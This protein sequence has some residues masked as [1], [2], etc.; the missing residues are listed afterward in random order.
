MTKFNFHD[1][2]E[3]LSE[4]GIIMEVT[5]IRQG[6]CSV[7]SENGVNFEYLPT[8]DVTNI[9]KS[10]LRLM[11]ACGQRPLYVNKGENWDISVE[12]K[13]NHK[14]DYILCGATSN[15]IKSACILQRQLAHLGSVVPIMKLASLSES[16][17]SRKQLQS[18]YYRKLIRNTFKSLEENRGLKHIVVVAHPKE[19]DAISFALTGKNFPQSSDVSM[20]MLRSGKI[21]S[22]FEPNNPDYITEGM[23]ETMLFHHINSSNCPKHLTKFK[24]KIKSLIGENYLSHKFRTRVR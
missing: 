16:A 7:E 1:K 12:S 10:A 13:P 6:T 17:I 22:N 24:G 5:L 11:Y 18:F 4:R 2:I 14:P 8:G 9:S 20:Q 15:S 19:L 21:I 23:L 3:K